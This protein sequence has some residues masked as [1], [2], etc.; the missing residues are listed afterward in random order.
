MAEGVSRHM[1]PEVATAGRTESAASRESDG[2]STHLARHAQALGEAA[3]TVMQH[4]YEYG[5]I[6]GNMGQRIVSSSDG[7][8]NIPGAAAHWRTARAIAVVGR[9]VETQGIC[10]V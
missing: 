9:D 10:S 6:S 4:Q 7:R 8:A 1:R 3:A 5:R 2:V